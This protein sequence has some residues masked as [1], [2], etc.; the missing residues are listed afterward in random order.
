MC[1][2][3][4]LCNKTSV[5]NGSVGD[6]KLNGHIFHSCRNYEYVEKGSFANCIPPKSN[7]VPLQKNAL[8]VFSCH[9]P[10]NMEF[11]DIILMV[12]RHIHNK[13][14]LPF[15][16]RPTSTY[17]TFIKPFIYCLVMIH[18]TIYCCQVNSITMG[19]FADILNHRDKYNKLENHQEIL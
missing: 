15:P 7:T 4:H 3:E 8:H 19:I 18:V 12:L 5:A 9:I 1:N 14:L 16:D 2:C 11:Q 10:W 17:V 13:H 6:I